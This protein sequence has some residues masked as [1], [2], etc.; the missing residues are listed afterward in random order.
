[1]NYLASV[2]V[3]LLVG[4]ACLL[5]GFLLERRRPAQAQSFGAMMFN[6]RYSVPYSFA[7]AVL[8][9]AAAGLTALAV[10]AVGG[11][12]IVLPSAGWELLPALLAYT[13]AMD[14]GEYVFHRAQHRFPLLW[15]MHSLHHSDPTLNVST[16]GRHYW[17]EN[18]IKVATIYLAV[19]LVF[20]V[21]P[22]V[23]GMYSLIT[24]YNYFSHMNLRVGFGRWSILANS[25]QYHR[26]H[27]STLPE[28]CNCN[29]AALFP[30]FDVVFGTYR[31]PRE[32]EYP[33]TGLDSGEHPSGLF[34]AIFWPVRSLLHRVLRK[35]TINCD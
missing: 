33:P 22:L 2:L 9:P 1:M 7:Q 5:I 3:A 32:N 28:H 26:I 29:F 14:F 19:G 31:Q 35:K 16:T 6:I 25:P 4:L 11:G 13:L 27:H 20:K 24:F 10:N 12:L 18:S 30:I 8:F 34:E 21:N 23:V 15:S 17:A